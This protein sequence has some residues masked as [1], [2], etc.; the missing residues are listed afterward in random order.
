M[1]ARFGQELVNFPYPGKM[2]KMWQEVSKYVRVVASE[3]PSQVECSRPSTVGSGLDKLMTGSSP[4]TD[5]IDTTHKLYPPPRCSVPL[6]RSE[7][8]S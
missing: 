7:L 4:S 5:V 6:P 1:Y 3:L 8:N 2:G